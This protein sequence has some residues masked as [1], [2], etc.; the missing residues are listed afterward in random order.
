TGLFISTGGFTP[1][2]RR[3]ARR[4]GA[5]VRLIDRD[6]FIDLWIRHQERVPEDARA[7]LRLVPVWFLDP[8]SPAL[9]APV[10]RH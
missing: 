2:A 10:C 3:E 1:D 4:P 5:R 7:R 8:A 9:V 6:E